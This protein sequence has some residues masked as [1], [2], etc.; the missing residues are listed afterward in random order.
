[1]KEIKAEK[2]KV[3]LQIQGCSEHV[4]PSIKHNEAEESKDAECSVKGR[5]R[6]QLK[7]RPLLA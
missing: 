5:Q 6:T 1:M 4:G 7:G 3:I 2:H